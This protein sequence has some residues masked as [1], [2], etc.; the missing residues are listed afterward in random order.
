MKYESYREDI[1]ELLE[2]NLVDNPTVGQQY[3]VRT[4][5]LRFWNQV[6]RPG[7]GSRVLAESLDQ[8]EWKDNLESIKDLI[9]C[10]D[11]CLTT[12]SDLREEQQ[13]IPEKDLSN[14]ILTKVQF[15]GD[16]VK[17]L[18]QS[19]RFDLFP[20]PK[21]SYPIVFLKEIDWFSLAHRDRFDVDLVTF[22]SFAEDFRYY[23]FAP[24]AIEVGLNVSH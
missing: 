14:L 7:R 1:G 17:G 12:A 16:T 10:L 2:V 11:D 4:L 6:F 18:V 9:F 24:S 21:L 13:K 22:M 15:L 8:V 3:V 19:S 23:D 20:N 5:V